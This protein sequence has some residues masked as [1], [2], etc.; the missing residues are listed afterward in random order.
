MALLSPH[1]MQL[2]LEQTAASYLS[3][4]CWVQGSYSVDSAPVFLC[5][6]IFLSSH[7]PS[8]LLSFLKFTSATWVFF[9]FLEARS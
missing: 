4:L 9:L 5:L 2:M 7:L 8:C 6:D 1:I 3:Q